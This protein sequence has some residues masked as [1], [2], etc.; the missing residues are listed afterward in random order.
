[1]NIALVYTNKGE[2]QGGGFTF[3]EEIL[4]EISNI[5]NKNL[6][7]F[8]FHTQKF[9]KHQKFENT[10]LIKKNY[11]NI[12]VESMIRNFSFISEREYLL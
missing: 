9:N 6:N 10:H 2:T 1:M 8:L 3:Q 4:K 7:F 12:F 5:K 11:Y